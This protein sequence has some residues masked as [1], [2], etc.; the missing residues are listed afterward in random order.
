LVELAE[1][2]KVLT[3]ISLK[4]I[5]TK[6]YI[7]IP[8]QKWYNTLLLVVGGIICLGYLKLIYT[9]FLFFYFNNLK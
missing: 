5:R 9:Y 8:K 4:F 7:Y 2:A 3:I 6:L 1:I